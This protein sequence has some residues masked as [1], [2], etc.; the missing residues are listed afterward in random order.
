MIRRVY[1]DP[2]ETGIDIREEE[3][4]DELSKEAFDMSIKYEPTKFDWIVT[5]VFGFVMLGLG[6]FAHG[7]FM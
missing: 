7:Y 6:W 3:R 5:I 2:L 1:K 4:Y